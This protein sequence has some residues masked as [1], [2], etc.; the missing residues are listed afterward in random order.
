MNE[1]KIGEIIKKFRKEKNLTIKDLAEQVN[2]TS[3]ML[4]QIERDLANPSLNTVRGI[5][6]ALD[7][8]L[9]KFFME[10]ENPKS[11]ELIVRSGNRMQISLDGTNY[12]LL[13]PTLDTTIEFMLLTLD[14]GSISVT[15]PTSHNGEEVAYVIEG[16]IELNLEGNTYVLETGDSVKIPQNM[17]HNWNN[18]GDKITTL[19]FAVTPPDF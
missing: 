18:N 3:S 10:Y 6:Q 15:K 11:E 9:F 14:P 2:I 5:S 4:S 13:T 17:R 7:V 12:Q 8:P 19:I 16:P 1:L